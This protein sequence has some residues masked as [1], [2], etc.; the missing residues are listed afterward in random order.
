MKTEIEAFF[1][2]YKYTNNVKKSNIGHKHRLCCCQRK[3]V[4]RDVPPCPRL[5]LALR[6]DIGV[7]MLSSSN[8]NH[9]LDDM[10]LARWEQDVSTVPSYIHG[11]LQC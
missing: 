10:D 1:D 5:V 7:A 4:C 6:A 3:C 8:T 9:V 11:C 2:Q